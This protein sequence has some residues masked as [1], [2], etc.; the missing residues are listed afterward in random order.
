MPI[1]VTGVRITVNNLLHKSSGF[2]L[3]ELLL[4]MAILTITASMA[5]LS[6]SDFGQRRHLRI[7]AEE[8]LN[9]LTMVKQISALK[10]HLFKIVIEKQTIKT[11]SYTAQ[12]EWILLQ[13]PSFFKPQP[14]GKRL[15]LSLKNTPYIL[16][17]P[18]GVISPFILDFTI[19]STPTHLEIAYANGASHFI[20]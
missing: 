16:I 1:L 20:E 5:L 9:Y 12:G 18:S 6:L 19:P 13:K 11:F 17:H 7:E 8:F 15:S 4:V 14:I 3:I 2:T 10:A